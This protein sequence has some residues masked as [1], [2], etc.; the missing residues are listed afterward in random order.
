[1]QQVFPA[2]P[3]GGSAQ[4]G[5][6][7]LDGPLE[8]HGGGTGGQPNLGRDLRQ[9]CPPEVEPQDRAV[10]FG[11]P[12]KGQEETV[13]LLL[14]C[15]QGGRGAASGGNG[16]PAQRDRGA[17]VLPSAAGP[18]A[19]GVPHRLPAEF[20][21]QEGKEGPPALKADSREFRPQVSQDRLDQVAGVEEPPQPRGEGAVSQPQEVREEV[22]QEF[23]GKQPVF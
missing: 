14:A 3:V 17:Q 2:E 11:K 12:D 19:A 6:G 1:M 5:L 10:P 9:G 22:G 16:E 20:L 4:Q 13:G 15:R 18:Q 7:A 21:G 23:V 8:G